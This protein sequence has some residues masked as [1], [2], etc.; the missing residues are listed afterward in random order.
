M[1]QYHVHTQVI[2][3]SDGRSAVAA[4]AYRSGSKLV[5]KIIDHKTGVTTEIVWDYS[6]KKGVVFS[7]I[8]IPEELVGLLDNY[9]REKLWND[10]AR[11]ELRKDSQ[12]A[13]EFDIALPV[14]LT[15]E[16]NID[17]L[18]EIATECFVKY[19]MIADCNM[20]F[21]DANNPHFHV[22]L[23]MRELAEKDD[24]SIDFGLKNRTWNSKIFLLSTREQV[25][26]ITNKHLELH[27]HL[28]RVSHLSHA[29]RGIELIPTVHEGPAAYINFSELKELNKQIIAENAAA[30]RE[31]PEL[32]FQKLSIN[33]P[34]FTKEEIASTLSDA[35]YTGIELS[36]EGRSEVDGNTVVLPSVTSSDDSAYVNSAA[37]KAD[38]RDSEELNQVFASEFMVA[39][40]KLMCSDKIS[41]INACDL[42]GRTLYALTKRVELEKRYLTTLQQ[43][44][45]ANK[46][47]LR[48]DESA[49]DPN[50]FRK[51]MISVKDFA[52]E[53]QSK[54]NKKFDLQL[55]LVTKD[56]KLTEEQSKAVLEISNGNDLATLE[57]W[58]GSGKTKMMKELV[59]QH[60]K[61]GYTVIGA[62]PSSSA[63]LM[64]AKATGIEAKNTAQW[65]KIWQEARG[66]EFELPLRGDYYKEEQYNRLD[67]SSLSA[68]SIRTSNILTNKH[69]LIIDEASM[70]E[71]ADMDY[72]I[73]NIK[74]AGGK[75]IK[76]GDNNQFQAVGMGGGF[77]KS[78]ERVGAS[79]LTEIM[80]HQHPDEWKQQM[81]RLATQLVG[82]Y[83]IHEALEIYKALDV[84]RI[85]Q[86]EQET[87]RQLVSDYIDE[88]LKLSKSLERDDLAS[89]R[90][91][92]VGAYTNEAVNYFNQQI[93][94]QLKQAGVL[95]GFGAKF[96]SGGNYAVELM[97]G[98]QIVFE[99][100]KSAFRDFPGVLNGE[101]AT[102]LKFGQVDEF[103]HGE[104]T[105][106]CHKADGSKQ[107][108]V[109]DTKDRL[110]PVKFRHG[111]AV[112]G[113][114]LQGETTDQM[115]VYF[116]KVFGYEAF[117][118][119]MS[120]HK[121]EVTLY[122]AEDLLENIVYER[123]N[124]EVEEVRKKFEIKAYKP[125]SGDMGRDKDGDLLREEVPGWY[126]GLA[127]SVSKRVNNNFAF[128]YRAN[129]VLSG[130]ELVIKNYLETRKLFFDLQGQMQQWAE[131]QSR[132]LPLSALH[133]RLAEKFEIKN[134]RQIFID[135]NGLMYAQNDVER[136]SS[137]KIVK[138]E[139]E[140]QALK[141]SLEAGNKDRASYDKEVKFAK[142][143]IEF[144]ADV[145]KLAEYFVSKIATG[146][147]VEGKVELVATD[148]NV[149]NGNIKVV[150][151][152]LDQE[153]IMARSEREQEQQGNESRANDL[154][155][156][157]DTGKAK[158][159]NLAKKQ[160]NMAILAS[161]PI[162]RIE[163]LQIIFD[164][165]QEAREELRKHARL[166]CDNYNN[167]V[168]REIASELL[169]KEDLPED[170]LAS[171]Q[172]QESSEAL[173][174]SEDLTNSKSS[175]FL[176]QMVE[177]LPI[178]K[179]IIDFEYKS[180]VT[181]GSKLLQLN[182]NYETIQKHAGYAPYKYF[183]K[184]IEDLRTIVAN[185]N[186]GKILENCYAGSQLASQP[187][188][189]SVDQPE[190]LPSVDYAVKQVAK[191]LAAIH[192]DIVE[193][194]SSIITANQKLDE[195]K[196]MASGIKREIEDIKNF[197]ERLVPEFLRRIY[198][199]PSEE[200]LDN[201][202]KLVRQ[203]AGDNFDLTASFDDALG[204]VKKHPQVLGKLRGIGLGTII[205][206]S[207][208][209][210]EA[211]V[212]MEVL[213]SRLRNYQKTGIRQ[214]ELTKKLVEGDY[215]NLQVNLLT[216]VKQL[217][218]LLPNEH[219]QRFM[220]SLVN[221]QQ[222]GGLN[223]KS[224]AKLVSSED[225]KGLLYEYYNY[226]EEVEKNKDFKGL[227]NIGID[228]GASENQRVRRRR[229][230]GIK[231][232]EGLE[233]NSKALTFKEV[234]SKLTEKEYREIFLQY[235]HLIHSK[236]KEV[237]DLGNKL[238]SGSIQ[239][240]CT[241]GKWTRFSRQGENGRFLGG[242]IFGFVGLATGIDAAEQLEIVAKIAGVSDSGGK[243]DSTMQDN[244]YNAEEL[245]PGSTDSSVS[246]S[247]V[248]KPATSQ[249]IAYGRV[250]EHV[251]AF[252]PKKD[253]RYLFKDKELDGIFSYRNEGGE[254]LGYTIRP[255]EKQ[256]GKKLGVLPVTYCHNGKEGI[257]RTEGWYQKGFTDANGYKPIYGLE[258]LRPSQNGKLLHN[259]S[260]ILIV[261]GEK[262]ADAAQAL[263]P[264]YI[265]ISWMGGSGAASK[266]DWRVLAGR[267]VV[268]W[269]DNDN[270]GFSAAKVIS[271]KLQGLANSCLVVDPRIFDLPEKWDLAD[272]IPE[273]VNISSALISPNN[274]KSINV[275]D[276]Q[277]GAINHEHLDNKQMIELLEK[278]VISFLVVSHKVRHNL[279]G[280]RLA[281]ELAVISKAGFAEDFLIAANISKFCRHMDIATGPGRGSA[282][283]SLVAYGLGIHK[284]DPIEHNL[285]FE[286][287]LTEK[288]TKNPDFD[289]DIAASKK[290]LVENYLCA[291]YSNATKLSVISNNKGNN[292]ANKSILSSIQEHE[293]GENTKKIDAQN[294]NNTEDIE[295]PA[296]EVK[297][298]IHPSGIGIIPEK[299]KTELSSASS[300][301][302]SK[303]W[304]ERNLL[305]IDHKEVEKLGVKKFDLLSSQVVESIDKVEKLV[306]NQVGRTINWQAI[307]LN[308]QAAFQL[309]KS[310][311]TE[312]I[313]QLSSGFAKDLCT[314]VK[315]NEFNDIVNL[316]A[317]IRPGTKNYIKYFA[318]EAKESSN[319]YGIN[320]GNR[321]F[322][323]PKGVFKETNGVP[324]FQE[325]IMQAVNCYLGIAKNETN[326]FRR[327]LEKGNSSK[328][329][330]A[331]KETQIKAA[332]E[333][334]LD[335]KDAS[336]FYH[337]LQEFS[338]FGYNKSHAVAYAEVTFKTAYLKAHY[339]KI[340]NEIFKVTSKQGTYDIDGEKSVLAA[341]NNGLNNYLATHHR[342]FAKAKIYSGSMEELFKVVKQ[343]QAA[344]SELVL[345]IQDHGDKRKLGD[346]ARVVI[347][348]AE[349][350]Q[351]KP[352]SFEEVKARAEDYM[353]KGIIRQAELSYLFKY[354]LDMNKMNQSMTTSF[355]DHHI[356]SN[357]RVFK[358]EKFK[359]EN[360]R[361][362]LKVLAKEQEFLIG[363]EGNIKHSS[364]EATTNK[365]IS[366][367]K[368]H[369]QDKVL[370]K[371]ATAIE[372]CLQNK[373][374]LPSE[375][376]KEITRDTEKLD[377]LRSTYIGLDRLCEAHQIET[378]L[379]L[380]SNEKAE[381]KS[382][383]T[384]FNAIIKEQNFLND[385][386]KNIKY[387]DRD[388]TLLSSMS[389][390][391][392][393]KQDNILPKLQ[394]LTKNIIDSGTRDEESLRQELQKT[395]DL[396]ETYVSLDQAFELHHIRSNLNSFREEKAEAKTPNEII[397][398]I[399]KEQEYLSNLSDNLKYPAAISS[400][401]L[402]S[403]KNAQ[404]RKDTIV[405][406]LHQLTT[407]ILKNQVMQEQD[408]VKSLQ[409]DKDIH[410]TSTELTKI[411]KNH[412]NSIVIK[413]VNSIIRQKHL[414]I[415]GHKFDCPIKYLEH[416]IVNPAHAY[417]DIARLKRDIP[418]VQEHLHKMELAKEMSK[419]MG[420]MSM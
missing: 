393:T 37:S 392:S 344:L 177:H 54:I 174:S 205:G 141:K 335:A 355:E 411:C 358:E 41:L 251:R 204:V 194:E 404:E 364:I 202:Q 253:M 348:A 304:A 15:K 197:R 71:L 333:N 382:L 178:S 150:S 370:E 377:G 19:G 192:E 330:L 109:I 307:S 124:Q 385:L 254:L 28:S 329:P 327:E 416:E 212:N 164:N 156:D 21:D 242:D 151:D 248:V 237:I 45:A 65:R 384:L 167:V 379:A 401:L 191:F 137:K 216:E 224:L 259:Y 9:E 303:F 24:N 340:F 1:A 46:H 102:V 341:D 8:F 234:N 57:G 51:L 402:N 302:A 97:I 83:K 44:A 398:I 42:R 64:L 412:H 60:Q 30:I 386:N 325:Q 264:D 332:M 257:D 313:Y 142:R 220:E 374:K 114:K 52:H 16:Q 12:L 322:S 375:I 410:A 380:F 90:S 112:T 281:E 373:L 183:L 122:A 218:L 89:I 185:S 279:Y 365:L 381:A 347:A 209:R 170:K 324:L 149:E 74:E 86:D 214:D 144:F 34:V 88:Y 328:H 17:L 73:T 195:T 265:V 395:T 298:T 172:G 26:V 308:D 274:R 76:V 208:K 231:A 139:E 117:N 310:G 96:K 267:D 6:K 369:Q 13:R 260:P 372:Y 118:V 113:Y 356:R 255:I 188:N 22:M 243:H 217:N 407:H 269:P 116:E 25:A 81:Q 77:K 190:K 336:N 84:F 342:A 244:L 389:K 319:N 105:V 94:E 33:K 362:L 337:L 276:Q 290:V 387:L 159:Q 262:T 200:V 199:T 85:C 418:R 318:E 158:W 98:E 92:V 300:R 282:V 152:G 49:L 136:T 394:E 240:D 11:R 252:E 414:E 126:V 346:E 349:S 326:D 140:L 129:S 289:F 383:G 286:R 378:N 165:L 154:A 239:M 53:T 146:E 246:I 292:T 288:T 321:Q 82:E 241:S 168:S 166:I 315:V 63:A 99:S 58:P 107:K 323:D 169:Q 272:P 229:V 189:Q 210:K 367:A 268:I 213:S 155:L 132:P 163:E 7:Q 261:E 62:A 198:Q 275:I 415:H 408:L 405:Q 273:G 187:V 284:V 147:N 225:F 312:G 247:A 106:L 32:V 316:L 235:V 293:N 245:I 27:G 227:T 361:E 376:S 153:Q 222:E 388:E 10:V 250:P 270:P 400:T 130:N 47:N 371:L 29:A 331:I 111:Y 230:S 299:L 277:I 207:Q 95:K 70:V 420:G 256:T 193:I 223:N 173:K 391:R 14:E 350:L 135:A 125:G 131:E 61:K 181:M 72:L 314:R 238:K 56:H 148:Q 5:E 417:A 351:N 171:G 266:V 184:P 368:E 180:K 66:E 339:P 280:A 211:I 162:E 75:C 23:T 287:F 390:A 78:V 186:W 295:N 413:N 161:L 50:L 160:K 91:L 406:E 219:E 93:R 108:I 354:E 291:K 201:W 120:R 228:S 157:S 67:H 100:N 352:I 39:Y 263:L 320:N 145:H 176:G 403:V 36:L 101:V 20:H 357:L 221:L 133:Q 409:S 226:R 343:E 338:K 40:Q 271:D 301:I 80:R 294:I 110:Y 3:K 31:N 297:S 123:M 134:V 236:P 182:L 283:S 366:V 59:L 306:E 35:L 232:K 48:L 43:F 138:L 360:Y 87:K 127:L 317:L 353:D 396:K 175:K 104:F 215:E 363:L 206:I 249:W 203:T 119:L 309:I 399:A 128:D 311:D 143:Q 359:T 115:F 2:G 305:T 334:G 296:S 278:E 68:F 121:Y 69:V 285:L 4:A 419:G 233:A 345:N 196:V 103:G 179:E 18:K 55:D 79:R 258:K 397:G 38:H